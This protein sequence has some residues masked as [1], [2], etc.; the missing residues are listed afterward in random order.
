MDVWGL[1][2]FVW[3]VGV[4]GGIFVPETA[5]RR[6]SVVVVSDGENEKGSARGGGVRGKGGGAKCCAY[7]YETCT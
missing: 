4:W 2:D 7:A 1:C 6:D 5:Y 3:V